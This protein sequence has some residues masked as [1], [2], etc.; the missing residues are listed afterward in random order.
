MKDN[1]L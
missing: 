1:P